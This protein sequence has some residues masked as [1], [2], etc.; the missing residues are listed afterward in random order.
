MS[1]EY[2]HWTCPRCRAL[3]IEQLHC[4]DCGACCPW[5][6]G[7]E[8]HEGKGEDE[9]SRK[10]DRMSEQ[11]IGSLAPWYGAKRTMAPVI[12]EAIGPHLVYWEPFCGS[13]AILLAKPRCGV[14]VVNDMH[15]D[16][17]NLARVI[18]HQRLGPALYRRLRRVWASEELCRGSVAVIRAD[19][20]VPEQPDAERA[21]HY[22]IASWQC[23]S[24]L[25]GTKTVNGNFAKRYTSNGGDPALRWNRA[26]ASI[27]A[28][29]KR[30]SLVQVLR[31]DGVG[32]CERIEDKGGTVVYCDPPYI[33]KGAKYLHDFAEADHERLAFALR[34]FE[35]TRVI[36]SYYAHDRLSRLYAGWHL[37]DTP[38][39][40]SLSNAGMRDQSGATVAPEVLLSNLPWPR[41]KDES[42][43][44]FGE[45]D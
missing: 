25:A 35:R 36:V 3:V 43:F 39:T 32:L 13:M 18:Q 15:G 10:A 21:F 33:E 4:P 41:A 17:I 38:I 37:R 26:V 1:D 2:L 27:P 6:C 16:L 40:K 11:I 9:P 34:R 7:E 28:W 19:T 24:G 31:S 44:M 14:E 23:M 29:R 8:G 42:A 45:D 22:F 5:G 12:V 30:L 20:P